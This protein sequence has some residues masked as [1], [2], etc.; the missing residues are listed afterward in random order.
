MFSSSK[1]AENP[2]DIKFMFRLPACLPSCVSGLFWHV[3]FSVSRASASASSACH[4]VKLNTQLCHI[5]S[6]TY[7]N[8]THTHLTRNFVTY[9]LSHTITPHTL[10]HTRSVTHTHKLNTQLCHIPSFTYDNFTHTN[11]THN[12]VTYHLS[13]TQT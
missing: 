8:F 1:S 11:L 2:L 5:P 6:F 13:H 4:F 10:C 7:K 12:F 3:C 9:H